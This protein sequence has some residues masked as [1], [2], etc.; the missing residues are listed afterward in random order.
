MLHSLCGFPARVFKAYYQVVPYNGFMG[1]CMR[2]RDAIAVANRTILFEQPLVP[3]GSLG[4]L[5][6]V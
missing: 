3:E 6:Y 4:L 1:T 5:G 2:A